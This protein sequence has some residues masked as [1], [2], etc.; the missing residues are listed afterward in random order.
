MRKK[1][2]KK[3]NNKKRRGAIEMRLTPT[4]DT[5]LEELKKGM[6]F[7]GGGFPLFH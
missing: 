5:L 6:V 1:K 4:K 2:K 3:T 7:M